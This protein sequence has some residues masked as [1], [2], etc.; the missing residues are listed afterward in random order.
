MGS[1]SV[2]FC[3]AMNFRAGAQVADPAHGGARLRVPDWPRCSEENQESQERSRAGALQPRRWGRLHTWLSAHLAGCTPGCLHTWR[4]DI[5]TGMQQQAPRF[6]AVP[7]STFPLLL[8]ATGML[9]S[10]TM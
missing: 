8:D 2:T 7:I 9:N 3:E 10:V 4:A 6:P 5:Q 1:I